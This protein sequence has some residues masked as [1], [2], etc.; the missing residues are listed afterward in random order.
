M[1]SNLLIKNYA[2]IR[3]LE[4]QPA[5][6][7]NIITGETG[8]G[9]SIMLG[10]IGLLLGQ[11]ADGKSLWQK[12]EK[13]IIEGTFN[14]SAYGISALFED[15]DW[16]YDEE[17]II[18][19]EI[20]TN[21]KSRA[22]INDS[23]VN[24]EALKI[25]GRHLLDIH[26]QHDTLQ[27]GAQEFQLKVLDLFG[28]H[29][30]IKQDYQN[31]F[32][33]WKTAIQRRQELQ[34]RSQNQQQEADYKKFLLE[35]L[36]AADLQA[37]EQQELESSLQVMEHAEEIKVQ[38]NLGLQA[39]DQ[40]EGNVQE[41]LAM[42]LKA[43]DR[44]QGYAPPYEALRARLNS[45]YIELQDLTQE[46]DNLEQQ[47]QY[48]PQEIEIR[49]SRLDLIYRLQQKHQ[50]Q[51]VEELLLLQQELENQQLEMSGLEQTLQD[52]TQEIAQAEAQV[53]KYGHEL[54]QARKKTFNT[55]TSLMEDLLHQLGMPDAVLKISHEQVAPGP[56]GMD[57]ILWQFS[58][59]KGIAPQPLKQ[60]ASGGEFSR[61]M[62]CVK[63]ILADKVALPTILFDEIDMGIS[64]EV[65]LQMVKMMQEMSRNHQVITIS[66]LPQ[67][68]AKGDHHYY[69]YKETSGATATSEI[70]RLQGEDRVAEVAKMLGG[71]N[72]SE[73]AYANAKELLEP[74]N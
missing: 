73:I 63:Y 27:L 45:A 54:S 68:A 51:S 28:Q 39:L 66:H 44:I 55:F 49:K 25:L 19:R 65:A 59:N 38:L 2:L 62:F 36:A 60:V 69:V 3:H 70:R 22:F 46:M 7:F 13:C 33:V 67:F 56:H 15:N 10:A 30:K 24:L 26:S 32:Q 50:V 71:N 9:K 5:A 4:M 52:L 57:N 16:E 41:L 12:Q 48:D 11:R 72:P 53:N 34:T 20:N 61:L 17:T 64:G 21:G 1:L 6:G 43:L 35:E 58:A 23:P 47:V 74:S 40:G 31:K 42:V 8:A 37:P 14:V 18:R 29:L